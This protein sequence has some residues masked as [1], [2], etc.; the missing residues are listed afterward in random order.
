[1]WKMR[2]V[3]QA[4]PTAGG[5]APLHHAGYPAARADARKRGNVCVLANTV[6]MADLLPAPLADFLSTHPDI[7]VALEDRPSREI[8]TT[9]AEVHAGIG[10]VSNAADLAAKLETFPM[11]EIRLV[12]AAPARHQ[13]SRRRGVAFR[14]ILDHD[15]VGLP[16]GSALRNYLEQYAARAG[17]RW[18]LR[19]RLNGFDPV[20][21]MV[22]SGIGLAVLPGPRRS[23]RNAPWRF[24]LFRSPT[25]GRGALVRISQDWQ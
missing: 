11:G 3:P 23:G 8:V 4:E 7:D 14:D 21:R 20:C 18:K 15:L 16:V 2:R 25:R 9:V 13:L 24:A 10:V 1:M 19:V 17:R 6:T 22:E 5:S 12:V